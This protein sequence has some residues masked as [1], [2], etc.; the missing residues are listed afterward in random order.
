M[1]RQVRLIFKRV[2]LNQQLALFDDP[3]FAKIR[4]YLDNTATDQCQEFAP[5]AS[6]DFAEQVQFWLYSLIPSFHHIDWP[7]SFWSIN[8]FQA[9]PCFDQ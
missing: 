9:R 2:D 7:Y 1:I 4:S 3:A 6:H 8:R 5:S